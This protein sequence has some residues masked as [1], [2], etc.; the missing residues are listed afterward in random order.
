MEVSVEE[1]K[2]CVV[3]G[4]SAVAAVSA[5]GSGDVSGCGHRADLV[6]HQGTDSKCGEQRGIPGGGHDSGGGVYGER[7]YY[8]DRTSCSRRRKQ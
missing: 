1:T 5:G 2:H 3:A 7:N 8:S 6:V 4:C